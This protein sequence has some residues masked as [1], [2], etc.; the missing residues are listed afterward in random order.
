MRIRAPPQNAGVSLFRETGPNTPGFTCST[1]RA[2]FTNVAVSGLAL[3]DEVT[4]AAGCVVVTPSA[5]TR[6]S[7][8][9]EAKACVSVEPMTAASATARSE[10]GTQ[11]IA[12]GIAGCAFVHV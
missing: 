1:R 8:P 4:S 11:L 5:S 12:A 6:P 10:V 2:P 3:I 9:T 7:Y